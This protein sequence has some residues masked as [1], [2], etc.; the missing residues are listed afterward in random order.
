MAHC[1]LGPGRDTNVYNSGDVIFVLQTAFA[2]M[3]S[4][5]ILTSLGT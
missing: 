5:V 1:N 3:Y 4:I 2:H